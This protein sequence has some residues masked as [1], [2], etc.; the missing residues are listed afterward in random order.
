MLF[1]EQGGYSGLH[2]WGVSPA[3]APIHPIP[4]VRTPSA[5]DLGMQ[6][7]GDLM[8]GGEP[9]WAVGSRRWGK[10]IPGVPSAPISV[11]HPC[12]RGVGMS[13][14]G[15]AAELH[16]GQVVSPTQGRLTAPGA[17]RVGPT[18]DFGVAFSDYGRLRPSL[19]L[20]NQPPKLRSM[21]FDGA[22]GR[23]DQGWVPETLRASGALPGRVFSDPLLTEMAAKKIHA[24]LIACQGG[25]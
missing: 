2:R 15:P 23:C 19:A 24:R 20:A 5:G 22:L 10:P 9:H 6:Q 3:A 1:F 8:M 13:P 14:G 21:G 18:P 12:C 16:P 4:S 11:L 17:V 7:A 25:A